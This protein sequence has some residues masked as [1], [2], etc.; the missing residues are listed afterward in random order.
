M[1]KVSVASAAFG[2]CGRFSSSGFEV[3]QFTSRYHKPL[4]CAED[5]PNPTPWIR[6]AWVWL[7]SESWRTHGSVQALQEPKSQKPICQDTHEQPCS[8]ASAVSNTGYSCKKRGTL[9]GPRYILNG[10]GSKSAEENQNSNKLK[11]ECKA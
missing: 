9:R 10:K 8:G 11:D 6:A 5:Y 7:G 2:P 1:S 4:S 3:L